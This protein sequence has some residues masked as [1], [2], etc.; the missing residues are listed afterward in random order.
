M[1][2]FLV[3]IGRS[4]VLLNKNQR[5]IE[6]QLGWEWKLSVNGVLIRYL[7]FG[8][9]INLQ[10]NF[11]FYN[12]MSKFDFYVIMFNNK[13]EL[14]TLLGNVLKCANLFS[15]SGRLHYTP[16]N[17]LFRIVFRLCL[18]PCHTTFIYN[19][20]QLQFSQKAT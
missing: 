3:V 7:F 4:L 18:V 13:I 11:P 19:L 15:L 8:D 20:G 14:L 5:L 10:P 2:S 16:I 9:W 12:L 17:S 6:I 1:L